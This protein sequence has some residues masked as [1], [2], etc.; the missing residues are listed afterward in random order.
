MNRE[1]IKLKEKEMVELYQELSFLRFLSVLFENKVID[2]L[3][4]NNAIERYLMYDNKD[5]E[6]NQNLQ[7]EIIL[8]ILDEVGITKEVFLKYA[9]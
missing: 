7:N 3:Y 9:K 6:G 1:V 2:K 8:N 4:Y 5:I